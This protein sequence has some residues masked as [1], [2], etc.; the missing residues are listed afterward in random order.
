MFHIS[1]H[2]YAEHSLLET[3]NLPS[4]EV[5][6]LLDPVTGAGITFEL[7]GY[8]STRTCHIKF[9]SMP[10]VKFYV[11]M[12]PDDCALPEVKFTRSGK[13]DVICTEMI[14]KLNESKVDAHATTSVLLRDY[15]HAL[16]LKTAETKSWVKRYKLENDEIARSVIRN[17]ISDESIDKFVDIV[18]THYKQQMESTIGFRE[19][20]NYL[21]SEDDMMQHYNTFKELFPLVHFTFQTL[22]SSRRFNEEKEFTSTQ[23]YVCFTRNRGQ[24]SSLNSMKISIGVRY[25]CPVPPGPKENAPKSR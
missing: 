8:V 20:R 14:K 2:S 12:K 24:S 5:D 3:P 21:I 11:Q 4:S 17:E 6:H 9:V 10:F 16:S 25:E 13:E 15:R 22:V 23:M 1:L 7:L 19:I 18:D